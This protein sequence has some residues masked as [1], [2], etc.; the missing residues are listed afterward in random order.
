MT[1]KILIHG[2]AG[3]IGGATARALGGAGVTL[4]LTGR[5]EAKLEQLG[6]ELAA[7]WTAGDVTDPGFFDRVASD[8]GERLDGLV[9]AVGNLRLKPL[10]RVT[11]EELLEDFR[12][13]G[14]GAALAVRAALPALRRAESGA[15]VVL[16]S[17]VAV[18]QGFPMH[19]SI[20]LAKGAVEGLTVA[21]AAELASAIR[22]NAVAPSLTRTPLA[23]KVLGSDAMVSALTALHPLQRLGAP[24]DVAALV[25]FLL[26]PESGWITGQVIG[27]DGGRSTL[28]PKG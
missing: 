10:A 14:A 13:H 25:A 21:L 6:R 5:D 23:A 4:H 9:Y 19:A 18:R 11:A 16:F 7:T 26:A 1:R 12:I 8:A 15:S 27:V 22:V 28:R 17:S 2:G 3:G 20:G 24:E